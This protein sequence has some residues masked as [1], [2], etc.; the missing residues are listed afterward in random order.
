MWVIFGHGIKPRTREIIVCAMMPMSI[1]II[2]LNILLQRMRA[3]S[4]VKVEE[5]KMVSISAS[6]YVDKILAH[7][8]NNHC[9]CLDFVPP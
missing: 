4:A 1:Y 9:S 8:I 6:N 5:L 3:N 2:T 7:L